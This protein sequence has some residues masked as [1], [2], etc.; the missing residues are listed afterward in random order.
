MRLGSITFIHATKRRQ[1][2]PSLQPLEPLK[3]PRLVAVLQ[4][5]Q[6]LPLL[7]LTRQIGA[8]LAA[9]FQLAASSL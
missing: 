1:K 4:L 8:W 5:L 3:L 2:R 6:L 7:Q 9:S